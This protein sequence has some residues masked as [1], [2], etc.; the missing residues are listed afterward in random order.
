MQR[1]PFREERVRARR[2]LEKLH[3]DIM[4]PIKPAS[5]QG[6]NRFI[7]TIMDYYSRYTRVFSIKHKSQAGECL[8][9]FLRKSGNLIGENVKVCFIREDCAKENLGGKFNQIME[10]EKIDGYFSPVYTPELGSMAERLN[11]TLEHKI[12]SMMV[13]SGLPPSMW[14]LAAEAATHMYNRTPH[15]SNN[16]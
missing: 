13:D 5:F 10:S 16:F 1:L 12:R 3:S 6:G 14:V 11:V 2:V 8:E 15:K 9:T 4:S 7:C